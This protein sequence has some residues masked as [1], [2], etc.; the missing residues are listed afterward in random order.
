[1]LNALFNRPLEALELDQ[2]EKN[3]NCN[4]L[5]RGGNLM[6][7]GESNKVL[8]RRLDFGQPDAGVVA[9]FEFL[10]RF[11]AQHAREVMRLLACELR[12]TVAHA[13]D[14]ETASRH[15]QFFYDNQ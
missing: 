14:E 4:R 9:D 11:D 3:S 13:R 2:R 15:V 5:G 1:M 12:A 7:D 8:P 6:Q 10:A